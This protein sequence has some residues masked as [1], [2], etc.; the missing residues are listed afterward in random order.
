MGFKKE[1]NARQVLKGSLGHKGNY[2]LKNNKVRGYFQGHQSNWRQLPLVPFDYF[3]AWHK[4]HTSMSEETFKS[5]TEGVW[6]MIGM[7]Q[8]AEN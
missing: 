7:A 2:M 8:F 4:M 5:F 1:A 3:E 6:I